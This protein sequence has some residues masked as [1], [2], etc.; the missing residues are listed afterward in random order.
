LFSVVISVIAAELACFRG[1]GLVEYSSKYWSVQN[2]CISF[3]WEV[4]W[5]WTFC[6]DVYIAKLCI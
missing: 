5:R 1:I 2:I 6:R 4:L 3:Q